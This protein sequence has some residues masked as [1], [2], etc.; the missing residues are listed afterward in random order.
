MLEMCSM[1][2]KASIEKTTSWGALSLGGYS[3]SEVFWFCH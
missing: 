2:S 1:D 3:M